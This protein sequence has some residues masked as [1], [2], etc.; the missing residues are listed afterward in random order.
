MARVKL[1]HPV[2]EIHGAFTRKGII[3]RRKKYRDERGRVVHEGIQE[4]YA[5]RHP[6]DWKTTPAQGAELVHHNRWREAC[7]RASQILQAA[8]PD[9]LTEQQRFHRQINHIP[10][11]YTQEEARGLYDL[12]KTRFLTQLPGKRG[13]KPDP[14]APIDHQTGYPKR[15]ILLPAFIRAMLYNALKSAG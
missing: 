12:Y 1:E 3:N 10:D 5:V 2:N 7:L 6:R 15:Y 9:G 14:E 11:F 4:A 13:S 8:Q